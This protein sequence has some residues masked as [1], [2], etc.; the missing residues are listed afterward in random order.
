MLQTKYHTN[1]LVNLIE[2][3]YLSSS[4]RKKHSFKE[5][6][7]FASKLPNR[8][9]NLLITLTSFIRNHVFVNIQ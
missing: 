4:L 9:V 2:F 5:E 1:F 7:P 3:R 6:T 8:L